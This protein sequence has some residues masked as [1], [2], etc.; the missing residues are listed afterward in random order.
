M[1]DTFGQHVSRREVWSAHAETLEGMSEVAQ[2]IAEIEDYMQNGPT[3][4]RL[5]PW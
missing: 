4:R 5:Y 1:L 3:Q 2:E